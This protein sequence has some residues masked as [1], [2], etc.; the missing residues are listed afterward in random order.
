MTGSYQDQNGN[1]RYFTEVVV[2]NLQFLDSKKSGQVNGQVSDTQTPQ[3][4]TEDPFS[5]FGDEIED[6]YLD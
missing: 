2:D 1:K 5:D 4:D 6:N 3:S